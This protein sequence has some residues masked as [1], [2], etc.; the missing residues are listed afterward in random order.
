MPKLTRKT[1]EMRLYKPRNLARVRINGTEIYLGKWGSDE[2]QQK[3]EKVLAEYFANGRSLPEPEPEIPDITV[4]ELVARYWEYAKSEFGDEPGTPARH[5]KPALREFRKMYGSCSAREFGPKKLKAF[6]ESWMR[7]K[8]SRKYINQ[9]IWRIRDMFSWAASEELI[10]ASVPQALDQVKGLRKRHTRQS[11]AVESEPVRPVDDQVIDATI[12]HLPTVV[13]DMVRFQR[14]TGARPSEVC[15]IRPCDIDRSGDVWV[16]K[17]TKH[18]TEHFGRIR[19]IAIGPRAQE[20]LRPYLLRPATSYCFSPQDSE[21]KRL[22][23]RRAARKTPLGYGNR[24]GT[25]RKEAPLRKAGECYTRDSYRRAVYRACDLAFPAPEPLA[26]REDESSQQW[27]LRLTERDKAAL[28]KWQQ[29]HRWTPNQLRH[30]FA[31]EVRREHG[32]EAAQ[33]LLGH[34]TADVTQVYAERDR[35]SAQRVALLLG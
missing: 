13:A 14:F 15:S 34:S 35:Q 33:V 29:D 12:E 5:M 32:L 22:H 3:Y 17:L 6:R 10:P 31:T 8:L 2:A 18:K 19:E 28:K 11:G 30:T 20:V 24:P 7:K 25:N 16:F 26:R 21:R 4:T 23:A 27:K 9:T 1:P